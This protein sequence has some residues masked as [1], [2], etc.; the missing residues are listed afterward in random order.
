MIC[1]KETE[2]VSYAKLLSRYELAKEKLT[3]VMDWINANR[4]E[5][6]Q[7]DFGEKAKDGVYFECCVVEAPALW[8]VH[9]SP[10]FRN[11]C[12]FSPC[13]HNAGTAD[14]RYVPKQAFSTHTVD[15][16]VIKG[17][18]LSQNRRV[19]G[20]RLCLLIL[21]ISIS[22]DHDVPAFS[23]AGTFFLLRYLKNG[24]EMSV[25]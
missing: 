21:Q 17:L 24:R 6:G 16:N 12:K 10:R 15:N 14:Q 5:N 23:K 22:V 4:N 7:W 20:Q 2:T 13:N 3:F 25:V 8:K 19:S 9:A 11:S 1:F 18:G